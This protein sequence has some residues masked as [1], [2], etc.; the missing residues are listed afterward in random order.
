M[1]LFRQLFD[2]ATS[3]IKDA[4][5]QK[6]NEIQESINQ[7]KQE[8]QDNL[9]Q[10]KQEHQER[11]GLRKEETRSSFTS[12]RSSESSEIK[13]DYGVIKDGVLEIEEGITELKEGSLARYKSLKEVIF[14]S[15]LTSLETHVFEDNAQLEKLDF[16]KVTKLEYI[17]D[18]FVFGA[19]KISELKIPYGVKHVGCACI[20]D[21][22][23][24]HMLEVYVSSTV[25][26]FEPFGA[27]HAV[28]FYLFTPDVDI[29]WLI[30]DAEQFNVLQ[31]DYY[32][33]QSQMEQY[34]GDVPVEFMGGCP[35]AFFYEL[36][37]GPETEEREEEHKQEDPSNNSTR[38]DISTAEEE[39]IKFSPR[40]E[41]LIKSAFRDGILT[42]KEKEIII[43]RAVSEGEDADE[44]E[45]LLSSRIAD[46]GIKE[47]E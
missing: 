27:N 19:N 43:K 44:F 15:S 7:R 37:E 12:N 42:K 26:K 25:R 29:E 45:L 14:P 32:R 24:T 9:H 36:I 23:R 2:D 30:D 35:E 31:K 17:P 6:K 13:T 28:T 21:I 4:M 5:E 34:G 39:Q 47:E 16:S 38:N 18:T 41:A 1:G 22:D 40:I 8:F 10:R 11:M 33:Y 46:E 20:C 3:S